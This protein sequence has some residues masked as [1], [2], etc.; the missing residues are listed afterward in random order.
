MSPGHRIVAFSLDHPKAV[1]GLMIALTLALGAMIPWVKVDTDPENMLSEH[2]AVRVFHH[3]M[4]REFTLH[5]MVVLGIVNEKDPDGVFNPASLARVYELTKFAEK[6][7]WPD[8]KNPGKE[9]GVVEVDLLAPSKVDNIEPV[10]GQPGTVRFEW[11]MPEPPT[12][13]EAARAIREK[14][15]AN[16]LLDGTLVSEDGKALCLYL[17]LTSKDLSYKVYSALQAKIA[18]L[19]G[20]EQ[21][22]IT[23]LPVA[24]DTFGVEMFKQM[25]ISAPLAMLVI[26]I[27][28]FIFFRKLTLILSPMILAMVSVIMTMGLLI[29]TG[30]TVHIMSSMIPIFIMPIAVLDSVHIISQFFD[31][32]QRTRDRRKTVVRVMDELFMPMLYTSLTTVAGFGSLALTPIPPVQVFG[33]FVA[34]G[35]AIA[36]VFT[37]T[38]VPAFVMLI[39]EKR[40]ESFG[41]MHH[42]EAPKS[43]LARIVHGFGGFAY[44]RA[45]LIIALTLLVVAVAGYGISRIVINDNPVKWFEKGHPIRVADKVLNEHFG[46]TYMAYL[47]LEPE[48]TA[49]KA[50]DV[51]KALDARLVKAVEGL[52]QDFPEAAPTIE[53]GRALVADLAKEAQTGDALLEQAARRVADLKAKASGDEADAWAEVAGAIGAEQLAKQVFKR[54]DV[55]R[56]IESLQQALLKTEVVGKS[57]SVADIVRKVYK[58]L[59]EGK[60]EF[61]R[62]PDTSA[63]VAQC[64]LSFQNSHDP[65][66]LWHLVTPDY[67]KANLWVQLKS[68]ENRDMEK[69]VRFVDAFLRDHKPPVP[70]NHGWFGLTY[71][72]IV[73]QD[74]MVSG[75][76]TSFMGSFAIVFVMMVVLFRSALWGLLA[77]VP[78]TVTIGLIYGII[79]LVGKDYD[80]PVAVL[81]ALSLGLAVDFAIHFLSR[82]RELM[83]E[84]GSWEKVA[85]RMFGE[86]ARAIARNIIVIAIGFLPLLAAPLVPYKTVGFF[87]ASILAIAGVTT[88]FVLTA[89]ITML[90]ARLFRAKAPQAAACNCGLCIAA[91]AGMVVVIA[92]S[93]NNYVTW[94]WTT[95]TW[96]SALATVVL[97]ALCGILSRR[98]ACRRA[99]IGTADERR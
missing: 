48:S 54:P 60:Q 25:A 97:T 66:D 47:V 13:R 59:M 5:D 83:H 26:F 57:N 35:V 49:R 75:M 68:G 37:V 69:V 55:L 93:I 30:H 2:E 86:P 80:M 70:L 84:L 19:T 41:T 14:A 18:T 22:H 15:K 21:Y 62:I 45:K 94:H 82:S 89:L 67:G 11:M 9:I 8:P 4:K 99:A 71:I 58:E 88:L 7:R 63:A 17:P 36:W 96:L 79:G 53:K 10:P 24:E 33:V 52:K 72:N 65:D 39:P 61:Y 64:L 6:L 81:S 46:G 29:G 3:E 77:M 40:F 43:L 74:K 27:L 42:D 78:L 28:M 12:T 44:H 50:D 32:Y 90:A 23:G 76:L 1:T 87:M 34:I 85:A 91:S 31:H 73:W 56:Y 38:F 16:P 98:Q 95:L 51:A 92:L 20:D